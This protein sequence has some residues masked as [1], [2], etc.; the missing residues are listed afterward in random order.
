MEILEIRKLIKRLIFDSEMK[1]NQITKINGS[2]LSLKLHGHK[3]FNL[4]DIFKL[5]ETFPDHSFVI[6][7]GNMTIEDVK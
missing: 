4:D 3:K 7:N 6:K 2:A 5:S 1:Q